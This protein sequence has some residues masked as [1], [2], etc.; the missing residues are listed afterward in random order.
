M[1]ERQS[2][3]VVHNRCRYKPIAPWCMPCDE[4]QQA[5]SLCSA[6]R[7]RTKSCFHCTTST[8]HNA[9]P[10]WA[11]T[12]TNQ[13]FTE[14]RD[15]EWQWHQLGHMQICTPIQ[16]DNHANTPSLGFY[17]LDALPATEPTCTAKYKKRTTHSKLPFGRKFR[18]WK[19]IRNEIW[20]VLPAK[21][22][23]FSS[24]I[25]VLVQM[26]LNASSSLW[27]ICTEFPTIVLTLMQFNLSTRRPCH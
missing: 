9:L 8:S 3:K 7:H 22:G 16:T 17:R 12:R 18:D 13:D 24:N 1:L 11:G 20:Y 14:A 6:G 27:Q 19:Y 4:H 26:S 10:R 25:T 15:S 2:D 23:Q 21:P 5:T